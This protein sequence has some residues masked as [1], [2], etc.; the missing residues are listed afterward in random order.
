MCCLHRKKEDLN[1]E[2]SQE[3]NYIIQCYCALI[4][5]AWGSQNLMF[6][7]AHFVMMLMPVHIGEEM[8]RFGDRLSLRNISLPLFIELVSVIF[9][10]IYYFWISYRLLI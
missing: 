5:G 4:L 1:M 9:L 7:F 8:S 3:L 6:R 2:S 10:L